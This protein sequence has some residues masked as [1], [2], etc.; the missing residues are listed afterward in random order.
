M[1]SIASMIAAGRAIG[2]VVSLSV[3]VG[4]GGSPSSDVGGPTASH[5]GLL[6]PLP[7]ASGLVELA[8]EPTD[9][10]LRGPKSKGRI[11]AYFSNPKGDGPPAA[12]ISEVAF[13][14]AS[15]KPVAL[16]EKPDAEAGSSRYESTELTLPAAAELHGRLAGKIGGE[17]FEVVNRPR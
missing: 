9:S 8:F 14:D 6:Q 15:D 3:V 17:S 16:A 10:A 12:A 2:V 13:T 7:K 1:S 4:C 11:V 5:G